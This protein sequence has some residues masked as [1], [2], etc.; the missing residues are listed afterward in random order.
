MFLFV[1][2]VTM[3]VLALFLIAPVSAMAD[4]DD[5]HQ[6]GEHAAVCACVCCVGTV[7]ANDTPAAFAS[8]PDKGSV[9]T[10]VATITG[11]LLPADIFRP[12]ASV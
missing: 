11:M 12:P 6:S 4:C 2:A 3:F 5:D 9:Y 8:V 10:V 7:F 1:R